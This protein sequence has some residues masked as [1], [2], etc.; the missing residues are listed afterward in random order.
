MSDGQESQN[1][2]QLLRLIAK[3]ILLVLIKKECKG[4]RR[5]EDAEKQEDR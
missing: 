2:Q 1:L 3:A 5:E 4:K